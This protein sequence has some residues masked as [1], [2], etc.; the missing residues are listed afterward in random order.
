[1]RATSPSAP[2][3]TPD[4]ASSRASDGASW[5]GSAC[6]SEEVPQES[7]RGAAGRRGDG[8]APRGGGGAAG[9]GVR[10]GGVSAAVVARP[11]G[12]KRPGGIAVVRGGA[13]LA[14]GPVLAGTNARGARPLDRG[15]RRGDIFGNHTS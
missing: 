2:A 11:V 7:A 13:A 5:R 15:G 9:L 4:P 14:R 6:G 8:R 10:F 1:M 12:P 3:S